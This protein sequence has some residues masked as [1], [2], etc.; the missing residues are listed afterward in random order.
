M[1]IN[2]TL[3]VLRLY[4]TK[5]REHF[6]KK[7]EWLSE[8]ST[9]KLTYADYPSNIY[10]YIYIYGYK[11]Y[12]KLATEVEGNPRASFSIATTPRCRRGA[13]SFPGLHHFTL[14]MYLIMLS[15]KQGGVKN[16]F[17]SLW[18]DSTR[19]S[20]A[21][22]IIYIYIYNANDD[23]YISSSS[24]RAACTDFLNSL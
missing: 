2:V 9:H 4:P 16:H 24:S 12:V 15:V 7:S 21:I 3:C 5:N 8:K 19:V 14:D 11:K 13:T 18:Y 20:R 6:P 22:G 23:I 10:I 1:P 17:L